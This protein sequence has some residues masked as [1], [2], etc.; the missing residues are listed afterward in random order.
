MLVPVPDM[1][2][3]QSGM[4]PIAFVTTDEG[5]RQSVLILVAMPYVVLS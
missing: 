1:A 5:L 4:D 2:K 3:L